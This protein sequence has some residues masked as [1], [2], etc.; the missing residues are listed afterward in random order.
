MRA[1]REEKT[2]KPDIN[3]VVEGECIDVAKQKEEE[4]FIA[5]A[6]DDTADKSEEVK[7]GEGA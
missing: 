4:N 1:L 3:G 6:S 5:N 2:V 7:E